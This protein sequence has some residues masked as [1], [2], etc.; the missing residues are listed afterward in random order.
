MPSAPIDPD[1]A[2]GDWLAKW[3]Y[4]H[5]GVHGV[6]VPENCRAAFTG[7]IERGVG[8]EC[9]IQLSADGKAMVFHD[10]ELDRL[11]AE[12]G[13]LDGRS[14]EE[15]AKVALGAGRETI[16]ALED[17]L[18]MVAGRVPLLIEIKSRHAIPVPPKCTAVRRALA[19]YGGEVAV[20]SFDPRVGRWF[21]IHAPEILRGLVVSEE[22]EPGVRGKLKRNLAAAHASPDFLAYDIR[23]LPSPF[24]AR[25]R[26][27]GKPVLTWTV[28]SPELRERADRYADA[29]IAEGVALE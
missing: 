10:W 27:G 1:S 22:G 21:S 4:A 13:P 9:D 11:S 6:G 7:A 24:A 14:A 20:M 29:P 25:H 8:I 19:G 16:P 23:D 17:L 26:R 5:R 28:N 18:Y 2:H 15:L 12:V 3:T